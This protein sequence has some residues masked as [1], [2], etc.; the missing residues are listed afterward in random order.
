MTTTNYQE[1]KIEMNCGQQFNTSDKSEM[2]N[3][4][5]QLLAMMKAD[6]E[7]NFAEGKIKE[8]WD[9]ETEE[10]FRETLGGATEEMRQKA[11]ER[12]TTTEEGQNFGA[13]GNV[14]FECSYWRH[15]PNPA[16]PCGVEVVSF[17]DYKKN[18]KDK[19]GSL[20][21][22]DDLHDSTH[23]VNL[24]LLKTTLG[25]RIPTGQKIVAVLVQTRSH[26]NWRNLVNPLV[27]YKSPLCCHETQ[28]GAYKKM[29]WGMERWV[30]D[31]PCGDVIVV[32]ADAK[33]KISH[34][35]Q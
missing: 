31:A 23:Y 17:E 21:F 20:M 35:Y 18:L 5:E 19:V 28:H 10:T 16:V 6:V 3:T 22:P 32:I 26:E 9:E 25:D 24:P 14:M 7:K 4:T 27:S 1:H 11:I 15:R 29:D 34:Q 8:N 33:R 2:T 13:V 30:S 12:M